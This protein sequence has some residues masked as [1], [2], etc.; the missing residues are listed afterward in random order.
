MRQPDIEGPRLAPVCHVER[1]GLRLSRTGAYALTAYVWG[2]PLVAMARIRLHG[3]N[4]DA[5]FASG[6]LPRP[7]LR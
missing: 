1:R 5:P 2:F 3:T 6:H 4:R 7:A